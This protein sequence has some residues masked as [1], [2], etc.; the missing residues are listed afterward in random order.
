VLILHLWVRACAC[1]CVGGGL[2][3]PAEFSVAHG[4]GTLPN[5]HEVPVRS[6]DTQS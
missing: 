2:C 6:L 4:V 3:D 5:Y 1:V